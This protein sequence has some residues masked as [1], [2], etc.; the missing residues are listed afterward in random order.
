MTISASTEPVYYC[1]HCGANSNEHTIR[2]Q[3]QYD[4]FEL[5]TCYNCGKDHIRNVK[6]NLLQAVRRVDGSTQ[7][8]PADEKLMISFSALMGIHRELSNI[9]DISS[10]IKDLLTPIQLSIA[11]RDAGVIIQAREEV[12]ND[13]RDHLSSRKVSFETNYPKGHDQ[14]DSAQAR[15]AEIDQTLMAL[16]AIE[17][18]RSEVKK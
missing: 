7:Q 12:L 6:P 14:R 9:D 3:E 11:E 16:D 8:L 13:L 5:I 17:S 10:H 18:L 1:P 15:I 2:C 4:E